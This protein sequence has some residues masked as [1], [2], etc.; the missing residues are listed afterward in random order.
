MGKSCGKNIIKLF[1][2]L[3]H[4]R[5]KQKKT[6]SK[7]NRKV[8][9]WNDSSALTSAKGVEGNADNS[10]VARLQRVRTLKE[11]GNESLKNQNF[12]AAISNY[13]RAISYLEGSTR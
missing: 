3:K 1:G 10:S 11:E 9:L 7:E 2:K 5:R 13:E 12:E 8:P 6:M 4:F